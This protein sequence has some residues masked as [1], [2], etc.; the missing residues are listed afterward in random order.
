MEFQ[1]NKLIFSILDWIRDFL[2]W[3]ISGLIS[4][5]KFE[6]KMHG[7]ENKILWNKQNIGIQGNLI[8]EF[9][10]TLMSINWIK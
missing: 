3:R 1:Q 7:L 2:L 8:E 6:N 5:D 9:T 4:S 10:K